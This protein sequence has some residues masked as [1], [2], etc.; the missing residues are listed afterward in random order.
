MW[1]LLLVCAMF[2]A[3]A[4]FEVR[5]VGGERLQGTLAK[6]T[7]QGV[8]L[9]TAEGDVSLPAED[10]V[11]LSPAKPLR[12]EAPGGAW[13]ELVDGSRLASID[14]AVRD[15]LAR[16][17][18][19]G[20]EVVELAGRHL[21][22]VQFQSQT[23]AIA[24][25]WS[26]IANS[27]R[28]TDLL[29]VRKN[30]SIDY[31][32]GVIRNV[33]DQTVEFEL[34]GDLLPVKRTKVHGLIYYRSASENLPEAVCRM[35]DV[36]GSSWAVRSISLE[37][38]KLVLTM[39]LGLSVTRP[40]A[41]VARID[42]SQGKVLYLGDLEPESSRWTPYFSPGKEVPV[43][44]QFFNP[45]KDRSLRPGELELAGRKYT[46]GLSLHSR[47]SLVYR[48]P[49]QFRRFKATVGIDDRVRPRG[50]VQLV[51]HGDQRELLSTTVTG[52][53]EPLPLDLDLT[54]V[55]RLTIL[56]DFG[57]DM[58]VADHLDLCD[59]RIVK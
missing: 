22:A 31:H 45:R 46:K 56:V 33:T 12:L 18:I 58:D 24:R 49:G 14:F 50:N 43:L 29:I 30:D 1:S 41:Q 13:V 57:S 55:R 25:Q 35:T 2:S 15:G 8:T 38:D 42:F 51:I 59:A 23:D 52:A 27:D 54:G 26:Q 40:L 34:D 17:T 5:T 9:R 11:G 20:G 44:S 28:D 4:Q 21:T 10:L 3:T 37:D 16:I 36:H 39:P 6:L 32:R 7:G 53:D 47:T 19:P 48:L